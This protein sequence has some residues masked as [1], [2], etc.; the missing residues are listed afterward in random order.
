MALTKMYITLFAALTSL[1]AVYG[2]LSSCPQPAFD[3]LAPHILP[4]FSLTKLADGLKHP[5]QVVVDQAKNLVISS[6]GDGIVGMK[7]AYDGAGCPSVTEKKVLVADDGRN[8]THSVVLSEN[9]KTL[10]ASTP[11][12]AYAFE[13]DA[14]SLSINGEPKTIVKG[15]AN[16]PK[17]M[18]I[19]RAMAVPKEFPHLLMVFRGEDNDTDYRSAEVSGGLYAQT[20][21]SYS[22]IVLMTTS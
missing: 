18:S 20:C 3:Y 7:V 16:S 12:Y 13:Y 2:Q 4:G 19:T 11:D 10:F 15:M 22:P 1:N 14:G 6:L 17:S 21:R 8:F 9:G 5:R